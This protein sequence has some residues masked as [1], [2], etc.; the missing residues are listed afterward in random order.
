MPKEGSGA[1]KYSTVSETYQKLY[2]QAKAGKVSGKQLAQKIESLK[3]YIRFKGDVASNLGRSLNYM[4]SGS[5]KQ[6]KTKSN[7]ELARQQQSE[8][9]RLRTELIQIRNQLGEKPPAPQPQQ[10]A[11]QTDQQG[12]DPVAK[13]LTTSSGKVYR[14]VQG[15]TLDKSGKLK[16]L[17]L[18]EG[19]KQVTIGARD[20]QVKAIQKGS[21]YVDLTEGRAIDTKTT[22][23]LDPTKERDYGLIA[24]LGVEP[25]LSEEAKSV[26]DFY[27]KE[28]E[29]DAQQEVYNV[30]AGTAGNMNELLGGAQYVTVKK[31]NGGYRVAINPRL[32]APET[33]KAELEKQLKAA[34]KKS[35]YAEVVEEDGTGGYI[36]RQKEITTPSYITSRAFKGDIPTEITLTPE[37]QTKVKFESG[38]EQTFEELTKEQQQ[39]VDALFGD[40]IGGMKQEQ[41]KQIQSNFQALAKP[42]FEN[43]TLVQ[44]KGKTVEVDARSSQKDWLKE[45]SDLSKGTGGPKPITLETTKSG[46]AK[47]PITE[48]YETDYSGQLEQSVKGLE[49]QSGLYIKESPIG[50]IRISKL[51]GFGGDIVETGVKSAASVGTS[52]GAAAIVGASEATGKKLSERERLTL[53]SDV[54]AGHQYSPAIPFFVAFETVPLLKGAKATTT[55]VTKSVGSFIPKAK[56]VSTYKSTEYGVKSIVQDYS[57]GGSI[58]FR[59]VTPEG[60]KGYTELELK[61]A[62]ST[63]SKAAF[64]IQ[65]TVNPVVTIGKAS[66]KTGAGFAGLQTGIETYAGGGVESLTKPGSQERIKTA[67]LFGATLGGGAQAFTQTKPFFQTKTSQ[68]KQSLEKVADLPAASLRETVKIG[69]EASEF[70]KQLYFF[71]KSDK[72]ALKFATPESKVYVPVELTR[73]R[74]NP[75]EYIKSA[76]KESPRIVEGVK[77]KQRSR[78]TAPKGETKL[79]PLPQ[80][81]TPVPTTATTYTFVAPLTLAGLNTLTGVKLNVSQL[82]KV[83]ERQVERLQEIQKQNERTRV[84]QKLK[85]IQKQKV[86]QKQRQKER[87]IELPKLQIKQG[88]QVKLKLGQK[89]KEPPRVPQRTVAVMPTFSLEDRPSKRSKR[90]KRTQEPDFGYTPSLAGVL[91]SVKETKIKPLYTGFEIRGISV[92]KGKKP[93]KKKK[94]GGLFSL[95]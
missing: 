55:T 82:E 27:Y 33:V 35:E 15:Y 92:G 76:P 31:T 43:I 81:K 46:I 94:K 3:D 17:I 40:V 44:D 70:N 90:P 95:L 72:Q 12:Y 34:A 59:K 69:K 86:K 52:L 32:T 61:Q 24:A 10:K 77:L 14:N 20:N 68:Y 19:S 84:R 42:S 50:E 28:V 58:I 56:P 30:A 62:A 93:K 73:T 74:I 37:R 2:E 36:I 64:P 6:Q 57:R 53:A 60:A 87:V 41:D 78:W 13:T 79:K 83:R 48:F 9:R 21:T 89:L 26:S 5:A 49:E 80:I 39:G 11:P 23:Q 7:F 85:I 65:K 45:V 29:Q 47:T 67:F 66:V 16:D 75:Y 88:L 38:K 1:S 51:V 54:V 8:A 22:R 71:A 91:L 63:I 25:R 4:K 18:K